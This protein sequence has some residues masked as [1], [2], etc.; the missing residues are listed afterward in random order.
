M[1]PKPFSALN[2]LTVPCAMYFSS[3]W[4]LIKAGTLRAGLGHSAR[5]TWAVG[6]EYPGFGGRRFTLATCLASM[7][8]HLHKDSYKNFMPVASGQ[9]ARR[10]IGINF[11][12]RVDQRYQR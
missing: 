11:V 10:T 1:K 9:R 4:I 5:R 12:Q 3:L 7:K 2:H 6:P 8:K